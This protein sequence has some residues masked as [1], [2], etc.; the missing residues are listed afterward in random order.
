MTACGEILNPPNGLSH[1]E[2]TLGV[3]ERGVSACWPFWVGFPDGWWHVFDGSGRLVGGL[4]RFSSV[5]PQAAGEGL[6]H[7]ARLPRASLLVGVFC[8]EW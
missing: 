2:R 6:L 7:R 4:G 5:T 8:T 1:L 3:R